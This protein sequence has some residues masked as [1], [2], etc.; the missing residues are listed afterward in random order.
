MCLAPHAHKYHERALFELQP[1]ALAEDKRR[2][3][4]RFWWLLRFDYPNHNVD[5]NSMPS[6]PARCDHGRGHSHVVKLYNANTDQ[7]V[8]SGDEMC[9]E[10]SDPESL[11]LPNFHLLE[12]QWVL[13]CVA[14]M[15]FGAEPQDETYDG[16]GDDVFDDILVMDDDYIS[17][18]DII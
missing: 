4:C 9:F 11:P 14:A 7:K 17:N 3:T 15:S 6:I 13:Q 12:M 18:I 5:L 1:I 10:K 16:D 2:L 8:C